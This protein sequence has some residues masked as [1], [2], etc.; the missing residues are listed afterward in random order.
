MSATLSATRVNVRHHL[1]DTALGNPAV[2]SLIL[3]RII[4]NAAMHLGSKIGLSLVWTASQVTLTAGSLSDSTLGAATTQF[5]RIIAARINAT[6]QIMEKVS[7]DE[8]NRLRAG[9]T[10]TAS[11]GDPQYFALWEDATQIVQ[12]RIDTVPASA[13]TID[14]LRSSLP[15]RTVADATVLPFSD[16]M[17]PAIELASAAQAVIRLPQATLDHLKLDRG[18]VAEWKQQSNELVRQ[19]RERQDKIQRRGYAVGF[20]T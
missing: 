13:R 9:L 7:F 14:F 5:D 11:Q 19:E 17:L 16:L 12:M 4:L 2:S 10:N 1:N 8:I 15:S 6:G 18:I 20:G 3:D